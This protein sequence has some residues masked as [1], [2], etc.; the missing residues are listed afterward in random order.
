MSKIEII[1]ELKAKNPE[2]N[3]SELEIL[4]KSQ[5]KSGYGKYLLDLLDEKS[6]YI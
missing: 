1:K 5:E 3:N 6:H 4:A 2:L